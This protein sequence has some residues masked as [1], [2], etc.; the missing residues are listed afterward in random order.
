MVIDPKT[1]YILVSKG[2]VEAHQLSEE[3]AHNSEVARK[4]VNAYVDQIATSAEKLAGIWND[5]L[6]SL[7]SEDFQNN[8][9]LIEI[10]RKKYGILPMPN[11]P[12][13]HELIEF[14]RVF[15]E[16]KLKMVNNP[17]W[18][19][20]ISKGIDTILTIRNENVNYLKIIIAHLDDPDLK[21]ERIE[22]YV[23]ILSNSVESLQNTAARLRALSNAIQII[24]LNC[25]QCLFF[26]VPSVVCSIAIRMV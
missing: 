18:D 5:I 13:Y 14:E 23:K 11:S 20:R 17:D 8:A 16:G 12:Y 21:K 26:P 10:L 24:N 15:E 2:L 1:F 22:E 6:N 3:D 9:E 25:Q 19:Q 7:V 4:Q